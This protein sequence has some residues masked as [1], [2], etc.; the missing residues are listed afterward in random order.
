MSPWFL[1]IPI[2][3]TAARFVHCR[4]LRV[5]DGA[6]GN[7]LS[8]RPDIRSEFRQESRSPH[9][10]FVL[11]EIKRGDQTSPR[12]PHEMHKYTAPFPLGLDALHIRLIV[13]STE[14]HEIR[15]PLAEF[16]DECGIFDCSELFERFD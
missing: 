6:L 10:H 8:I 15:L 1:L 9:G 13:V 5:D 2:L 7:C 11:V 4:R 3:A 12:S 16:E 14:W